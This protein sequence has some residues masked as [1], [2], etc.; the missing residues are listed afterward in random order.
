MTVRSL[1]VLTLSLSFTPLCHAVYDPKEYNIWHIQAGVLYGATQTEDEEPVLISIAGPTTPWANM[2]ISLVSSE[3][4]SIN[5]TTTEFA[6]NNEMFAVE[7]SCLTS[8][9]RTVI[10][11]T[12]HDANKV[13][14]LYH[15]LKS[16]FTVTLD[17]RIKVWAA[18]IGSPI[19]SD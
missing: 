6:F 17:K 3:P 2:V 12:L 4:C 16:G 18:N 15:Q 10:S 7:Y 8:A 11:Y 9:S 5:K 14:K 1:L 13:N 19:S